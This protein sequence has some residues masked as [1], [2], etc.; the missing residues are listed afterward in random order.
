VPCRRKDGTTFAGD[1]AVSQVQL[2]ERTLFTGVLRDLTERKRA[3]Q[4]LLE[5]TERVRAAE[6]LA[7]VGTL[8]AGLAHEIGTPMGVIQ[9]HAKML[10]RHLSDDRARWRLSTIQ[11][12]VSRISRIIQSLL[13]MA[14]PKATE[15]LPVALEPLLET[16]LSF[17]SEK[18]ARREVEIVRDFQSVSSILGDPERLQQLLL[19]LF[20][21]A[22]DAMPD[23]GELRIRLAPDGHAG[24]HLTVA[25]TGCGI[26][27]ENLAQIFEPFYTSKEA[28]TGNGLGLMV[29]SRIVNDHGGSMDVESRVGEGT[30]FLI[31]LPWNP[32]PSK[33]EGR[34]SS[35][36]TSQ[37]Q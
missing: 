28:G 31:H 5:A 36:Q 27:K 19:N 6:E 15:R 21:N 17:L 11:E 13:N 35:D 10:E 33:A 12:Q 2:S 7:S 25:D 4:Q 24:I 22:V 37:M 18:F 29:A 1:L 20:L 30:Q 9:G 23:G 14:R 3:E 8:V 26:P 32:A 34:D 16:T